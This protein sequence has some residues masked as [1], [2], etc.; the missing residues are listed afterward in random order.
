MPAKA[1]VGPCALQATAPPRGIAQAR[2]APAASCLSRAFP[3]DWHPGVQ[4]CRP[5]R[6]PASAGALS[7][8]TYRGQ[9]VRSAAEM[10]TGWGDLTVEVRRRDGQARGGG[11]E[12]SAAGVAHHLST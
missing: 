6:Q 10:A 4:S 8:H 5:R 9:G 1:A 12:R 7:A 3:S 2:Q 11:T